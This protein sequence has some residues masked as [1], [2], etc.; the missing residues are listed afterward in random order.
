MCSNNAVLSGFVSQLIECKQERIRYEIS[1]CR[2]CQ[3]QLTS[4]SVCYSTQRWCINSNN[5]HEII[6]ALNLN[7]QAAHAAVEADVL[8][9]R[10]SVE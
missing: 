1:P 7:E 5:L 3:Y 10:N 8:N 2:G 4:G 6:R 9:N